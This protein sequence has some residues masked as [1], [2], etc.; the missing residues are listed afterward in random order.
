MLVMSFPQH[1]Y[2]CIFGEGAVFCLAQA[3][4]DILLDTRH[5]ISLCQVA[6]AEILIM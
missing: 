3:I 1:V 5:S 4:F 6:G 2:T